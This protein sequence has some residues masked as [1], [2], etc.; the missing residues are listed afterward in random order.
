L[1][2]DT[3]KLYA[4]LEWQVKNRTLEKQTV[5]YKVG[6]GIE[7]ENKSVRE[8]KSE[9]RNYIKP[10]DETEFVILIRSWKVDLKSEKMRREGEG[11][12]ENV[13]QLTASS[14]RRRLRT[15]F[16]PDP[17]LSLCRC[18][19]FLVILSSFFCIAVNVLSAIRSFKNQSDVS[20]SLSKV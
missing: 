19:S 6:I 17:F 12:R 15:K 1:Y 2:T 5:T 20:L 8:E 4:W 9:W 3:C 7:I 13:P 18:F 14:T 16:R 11:E 10:L